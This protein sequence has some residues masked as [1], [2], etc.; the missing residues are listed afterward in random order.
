MPRKRL[1][2]GALLAIG[3]AVGGAGMPA[4]AQDALVSHNPNGSVNQ[5]FDF[6]EGRGEPT[7]I[8]PEV[9]LN[10]GLLNRLF[11][12]FDP[13]PGQDPRVLTAQSTVSDVWGVV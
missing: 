7:T 12:F 4:W 1:L 8:V 6:P 5:R 2:S 9:G 10:P 3:L 13:T 11:V